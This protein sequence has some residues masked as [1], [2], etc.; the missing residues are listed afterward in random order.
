MPPDSTINPGVQDPIVIPSFIK[1]I[2]SISARS[3]IMSGLPAN[4]ILVDLGVV[5]ESLPDVAGNSVQSP[6]LIIEAICI[7]SKS[8]FPHRETAQK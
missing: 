1:S 4:F 5:L 7:P 8:N 6:Q 3:N 2:E